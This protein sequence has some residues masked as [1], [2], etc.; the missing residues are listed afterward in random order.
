M[1][2]YFNP[3]EHVEG[4]S[5]PLWMLLMVPAHWL[6]GD[7]SLPPFAKLLG[8]MCGAGT[9]LLA[10]R[11][12]A[13]LLRKS[14]VGEET[15]SWIGVAAAALV[16][17]HPG[18]ALN[19]VSGLETLLFGFLLFLGLFLGFRTLERG[20]HQGAGWGFALALATRPEAPVLIAAIGLGLVTMAWLR[21]RASGDTGIHTLWLRTRCLL[22]DALL[23]I[24]TL[25]AI[26]LVRHS[27]YDGE[28]LP[29]T[30]FAKSGGFVWGDGLDYMKEGLLDTVFGL[31]GLA[32]AVGGLALLGRRVPEVIPLGLAALTGSLLPLYMG[33]DWML[34]GRFLMPHLPTV[35][36]AV[37]L[38][39]AYL[40]S[41]FV[42]ERAPLVPCVL[43]ACVA[44]L[45][46]QQSALT[47]RLWLQSAIQA[48]GYQ[49]GHIAIADWMCGS[50]TR[51]GETIAIMDI[52]I[53]G[54]RCPNQRILDVSGLTDRF[55]AKSEG[56]F[57]AKRYEPS[58]ILEQAP[59]YV[60]LV[61]TAEG[62]ASQPPAHETRFDWWTSPER[63]LFQDPKFQAN[64]VA[65]EVAALRSDWE[66]E[67]ERPAW[68]YALA[69][70][71]GATRIFNHAHL[72]RYYLLVLFERQSEPHALAVRLD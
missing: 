72:G 3:A 5:N 30:Y 11:I 64:Y 37:V 1:G 21:M 6:G 10:W 32:C 34:G 61:L 27:L 52:G 56:G 63:R 40:L 38:G 44:L 71:V 29:N 25:V 22:P 43:F 15:A 31:P 49:T 28:W 20:R 16:V 24:A 9:L 39:W 65:H 41:R 51:G 12:T 4:Y 50:R 33:M 35:A 53:V 7:A 18:Y 23:P 69:A 58:Y 19:S 70:D 14:P 62:R 59:R 46:W 26:L 47:E 42:P 36:C 54:Y 57:L 17:S 67:G 60:V 55:I 2:P 68:M 48:Q 13:D 8:V 66:A 45:A